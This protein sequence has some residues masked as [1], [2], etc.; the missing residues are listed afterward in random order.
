MPI[1][2]RVE[3]LKLRYFWRIS[4]NQ[5]N[6]LASCIL[7]QNRKNVNNFKVG[8]AHEVFSLCGK[9]NCYDVWLKLRKPKENPMNTIRKLVEKH[10][11]DKDL[12]KCAQTSCM[13][14]NIVLNTDVI[15]NKR[16]RMCPIFEHMGIFPSTAERSLFLYAMLDPCNF[17]SCCHLCGNNFKDVLAHKLKD[18]EETVT[19]RTRLKAKLKF[20][21][22]P[23]IDQANNKEHLFRIS[24]HNAVNSNGAYLKALCEFL[25]CAQPT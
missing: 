3:M 13:Y 1:S 24:I 12:E 10:Y 20:Y 21:N 18:C 8:F 15:G 4:S 16:Y 11:L 2:A 19:L 23:G 9:L 5:E 14:T 25:K 22:A 17:L 6:T 7:E